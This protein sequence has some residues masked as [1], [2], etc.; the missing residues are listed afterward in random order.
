MVYTADFLMSFKIFFAAIFLYVL[1][2]ALLS[3]IK[4][5]GDNKKVYAIIAFISAIFVSFSGVLAYTLLYAITW[6]SVIITILLL[7]FIIMLFTG[8][9][10][11]DI[12]KFF[13]GN[14]KTVFIVIA[15]LFL[16]IFVKAFFVLNN[17]FDTSNP[18]NSTYDVS[19]QF[20][21][22][23]DDVITQKEKD[24]FMNFH[25]SDEML[26]SIIFLLMMGIFVFLLK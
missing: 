15:V 11:S 5:F 18:P 7:I 24:S 23:V 26:S 3:K 8:I 25:I 6:F 2:F 20:N 14:T 9:K 22:G 1:I 17:S 19:T 12:E 21:T 16:I 13:S 4:I 10:L